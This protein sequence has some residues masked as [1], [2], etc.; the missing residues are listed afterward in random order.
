MAKEELKAPEVENVHPES[1]DAKQLAAYAGQL[2]E[3]LKIV[4]KSLH[5]A[6]KELEM[7]QMQDYYQRA[8]LLMAVLDHKNVSPEFQKKCHDELISLVF[9]PVKEPE[10]KK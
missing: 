1:L 8:Q 3:R 5:E 4:L 6:K 7:Y 10:P 9:P 2:E